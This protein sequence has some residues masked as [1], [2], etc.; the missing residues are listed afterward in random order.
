MSLNV[1]RN[2]SSVQNL[3]GGVSRRILSYSEN[4]MPVEV[5]FET[6]SIGEIHSHP[7]IQCTVIL[8]G[9]FKFNVDGEE[10]IVS[11]GDSLTFEADQ[12]HGTICLEKGVLLDIFTP[13]RKD[14][15]K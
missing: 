6:G 10:V 11:E 3:G 8:S 4:L 1:T 15:I 9:K 12:K 7:H 14:F 5:S 13:M 2:N